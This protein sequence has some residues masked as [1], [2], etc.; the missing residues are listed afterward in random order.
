MQKLKTRKFILRVI[1]QYPNPIGWD[2]KTTH[3]N[4]GRN[5]KT[6]AISEV[7]YTYISIVLN[8]L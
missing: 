2:M 3:L 1:E 7:L 6:K 5:I 8:D 4:T